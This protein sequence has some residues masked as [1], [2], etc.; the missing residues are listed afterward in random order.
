M[1][2]IIGSAIVLL[3]VVVLVGGGVTVVAHQLRPEPHSVES[4]RFRN[5]QAM[6]RWIE[7]ILRDDK[8]NHAIPPADQERARTLLATFY[9]ERPLRG[10][11]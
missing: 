10:A 7:T 3:A 11:R 1:G 6:A 2:E 4:P 5:H 9:D 8:V